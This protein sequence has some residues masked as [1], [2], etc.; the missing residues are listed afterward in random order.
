MKVKVY[1]AGSIG[2]H[3][4]HAARCMG[5]DVT[6][7]DP[8][9]GALKRTKEQIYPQRY[10]AWDEGIKLC[11]NKD[12]PKGGFD[13]I[14]LGT[15]PDI[16]FRLAREC[17]EERPRLMQL[18]KPLCGPNLKDAQELFEDVAKTDTLMCV[19]YDHVLGRATEMA[20]NL[21]LEGRWGNVET[22][23]VEFRE[24][25]GGIFSAHPWLTGPQETYLGHWQRGGGASGEH[26]HAT[27]MWQHFAHRLNA[28]RI[29]E[30]TA[31]MEMVTVGDAQ[32]DKLCAMTVKTEKGL[33]GRVVQDVVTKPPRKWARIQ[34]EGGYIEWQCGG[35]PDGDVV[36]YQR[37]GYACGE[38]FVP[39]K[40]PD[41]FILEMQHF[42]KL[43]KK[44]TTLDQSAISL[45]RGLDTA[46]VIAAAHKS[47]QEKRTVTIDYSKGYRLEAIR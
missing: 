16:R 44:E 12:A 21:W 13:M 37:D 38:T 19:G 47:F 23:D 24:H 32:Y 45:Q 26:S 41:D 11:E 20:E 1:G 8:D 22:L 15:P 6:I 10:G 3:L 29:I 5:W 40:R 25:W 39:K 9:S 33:L 36:R 43:L 28:G 4:A 2:N 31:Q 7:C 46:L 30:V 14:F 35:R 18:E 27:N 34:C 17:L 42:N